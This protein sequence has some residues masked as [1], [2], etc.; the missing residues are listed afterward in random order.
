M[1]NVDFPSIDFYD[2]RYTVGK[3]NSLVDQG[4]DPKDAL[5]SL[6]MMSRDNVR[7]PMQWSDGNN[8]GFSSGK[9]WL[10]VNPTYRSINV[11]AALN[12][13]TSIFY[14]YQKLIALRKEH[15]VMVYGDYCPVMEEYENIVAYTRE[16][17]GEKWLM[18]FNFQKAGQRVIFPDKLDIANSRVLM[19]NYNNI[20]D[21]ALFRPYEGRIYVIAAE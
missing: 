5:D 20:P 15:P 21:Q 8:A 2:E 6:K 3:Y 7:T 4:V 13:P 12:D 18:I 10:T 14:T 17:E 1:V 9:P 19:C 16:F 11:A